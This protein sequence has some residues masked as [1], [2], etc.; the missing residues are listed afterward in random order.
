MPKGDQ[1]PADKQDDSHDDPAVT[2]SEGMQQQHK[3]ERHQEDTPPLSDTLLIDAT[4]AEQQ[5]QY[6]TD[7]NLLNQSREQLEGMISR[8]CEG[9]GIAQPRTYKKVA[10]RQYLLTAKRSI[11]VKGSCAVAFAGNCSMLKGIWLY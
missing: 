9:L 3:E 1:Q 4:V 7:L 2:T 10:R 8:V 11:R 5:I 6:P